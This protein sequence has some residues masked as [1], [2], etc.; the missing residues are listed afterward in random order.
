MCG[1]FSASPWAFTRTLQAQDSSPS[2]TLTQE[3]RLTSSPL[4]AS[5]RLAILSGR[6][7]SCSLGDAFCLRS[8]S[9]RAS[10]EGDSVLMALDL[11]PRKGEVALG[12][13]GL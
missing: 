11:T 13:C 1:P 6:E 5:Q 9:L 10:L 2:E 12:T 4:L 3:A 7:K 8:G